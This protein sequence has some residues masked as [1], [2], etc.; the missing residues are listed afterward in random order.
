MTF[1]PLLLACLLGVSFASPVLAAPQAPAKPAASSTVA[2]KSTKKSATKSTPAKTKRKAVR[3]SRGRRVAQRA[4]GLVGASLARHRVPDDCS[5]LV[6][7]AYQSVG[8][9][10]LS[11]GTRPGENAASAMYRRAQAKGA[12]HRKTPQ[13]GDIIFFRETYDR[14]RDG[15]R[16]DGV[17]HVG[18]IESVARD[19]TV[20]FVHRGG[21]GVG[22]A[23]MNLRHAGHQ[24]AGG[25]VLNDYI[26]KAEQGERARLTSELFVGYASA[27][28]L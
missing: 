19:G 11:H 9:E 3:P 23:R 12:L 16:N 18:V 27:T 14:N 17:T 24:G 26:R 1:R 4:A 6:R 2:K 25:R 13:P 28:R 21:K 15:L 5:G 20:V 7:L 10:L 8:V 22:R